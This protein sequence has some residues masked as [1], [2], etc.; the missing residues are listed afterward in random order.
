M[1]VCDLCGKELE[2][3]HF[4]L[5]ITKL[6]MLCYDVYSKSLGKFDLCDKCAKRISK[7]IKGGNV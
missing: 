7:K 3:D 1:I 4:T 5:N 6:D 2:K